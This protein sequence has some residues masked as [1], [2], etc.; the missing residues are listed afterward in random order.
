MAVGT[1]TMQSLEQQTG[2]SARTLRHWIRQKVMP[3]PIGRGR[4]ARYDDRH[5]VRARAVQH[6]RTSGRLSLAAIRSRISPLS[7][8]QVLALIPP[9]PRPTTPDGVPVPPPA[10]TYPAQTWEVVVLMDGLLLM[11]NPSQGAVLRRIA[12]EIY[13]YYAAPRAK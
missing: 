5:V 8:E 6:L 2:V 3:K 13:R 9:L 10:P 7:D 12:D 1:F 4:G 11:V